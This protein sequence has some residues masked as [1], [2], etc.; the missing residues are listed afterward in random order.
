MGS[1]DAMRLRIL[2]L[3]A[4]STLVLTACR[5]A[6]PTVPAVTASSSLFGQ[7]TD[8]RAVTRHTLANRNGML[9]KVLDL[10]C[11]ISEL[12]VPD[13]EGRTAS[14]VVGADELDW[15]VKGGP[16][17]YVVGRFANRIANAKFT[18]DGSERLV[19]RNSGKHHIHGGR[20]GFERK[21]WKSRVSRLSGSE[22]SVELTYHSADGE[23]GFPGNLDVT[24]TY[25]LT[26]DNELR[27]HYRAVSDKA[28]PLNL[29]N[30]AYFNLA[31]GGDALGHA[32]TINSDRILETD[33]ERIPSG[34]I[35]GV[36]GTPF[37]FRNPVA[38]GKRHLETGILPGGYDN[39][40]VLSPAVKGTVLFAARVADPKSG[41]VMEVFTDAPAIQLYSANHFSQERPVRGMGGASFGRYGALCFET[42]QYPDAPNNPNF[43]DCVVRPGREWESTTV[44]RFSVE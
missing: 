8:G 20:E 33:G 16:G 25:T 10:G 39:T 24:V 37:D 15:F 2:L 27:V 42:E 38:A 21:L 30:H 35:L 44:F 32:V 1:D 14:V 43:P 6:L 17:A 26:E 41:R 40:Y 3:F 19:T 12:Q 29:T 5:H 18:L 9:V 13:R 28:T 4:V 22:A 36:E 34:K 7:L 31:G 23:E 11:A